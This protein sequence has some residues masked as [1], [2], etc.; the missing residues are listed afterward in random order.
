MLLSELDLNRHFLKPQTSACLS[1]NPFFQSYAAVDCISARTNGLSRMRRMLY[2]FKTNGKFQFSYVFY[3]IAIRK[4]KS[5]WRRQS[6]NDEIPL[7]I[8]DLFCKQFVWITWY[9]LNLHCGLPCYKNDEASRVLLL[10][11]RLQIYYEVPILSPNIEQFL[12]L[13]FHFFDAVSSAAIL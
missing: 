1:F 12:M 13:A 5:P 9:E 7:I 11:S 8:T 4:E 3:F 10:T 6:K 2:C